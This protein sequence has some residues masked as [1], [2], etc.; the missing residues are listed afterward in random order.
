M[1]SIP[2]P[3]P[4]GKTGVSH[5]R[6]MGLAAVAVAI[7]VLV[8]VPGVRRTW[9]DSARA[10]SPAKAVPAVPVHTVKVQRESVPIVSVGV[11]SV[12]PVA[13]V[14]VRTRID[15]QLD[16]V[17]FK[18]GQDVKAGQV[19]AHIDPRTLQAQL[20]QIEAQKAKD[21]ATLANARADLQR[22]S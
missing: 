2:S 14:T 18:E 4:Q 12:L 16:R 19:L 8:A 5:R 7:A 6:A 10:A 9:M 13:S 1:P 15:G 22:Y 11:G 21:E 17:D 20:Q 3:A